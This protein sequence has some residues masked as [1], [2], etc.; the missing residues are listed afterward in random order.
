M[1]MMRRKIVADF[2]GILFGMLV[3]TL[4]VLEI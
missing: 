4:S 3:G 1:L 2:C